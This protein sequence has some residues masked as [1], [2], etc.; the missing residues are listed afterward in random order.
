M[1]ASGRRV[2]WS[3]VVGRRARMQVEVLGPRHADWSCSWVARDGIGGAMGISMGFWVSSEGSMMIGSGDSVGGM[4]S[5]TVRVVADAAEEEPSAEACEAEA[6]EKVEES[7][8]DLELADF[9]LFLSTFGESFL[10]V[11]S[12]GG[13]AYLFRNSLIGAMDISPS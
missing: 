11:G 8:E 2:S 10:V 12:A 1:A 9:L 6:A 5:S 13:G 4:L 7:D 3:G